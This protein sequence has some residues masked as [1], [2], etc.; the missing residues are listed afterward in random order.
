MF[1]YYG[2][3][4]IYTQEWDPSLRTS[5]VFSIVVVSNCIATN[6]VGGLLLSTSSPAS[7]AWRLLDD[8][9]PDL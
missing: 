2:F 7:I 6:S 3:L 4:Q 9:H 5:T 1:S 8:G